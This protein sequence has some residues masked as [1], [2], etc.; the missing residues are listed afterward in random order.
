MH[1]TEYFCIVHLIYFHCIFAVCST[2][3][4]EG[5]EEDAVYEN[6]Q[7]QTFEAEDQ[8]LLNN[9]GKCNWSYCAQTKDIDDFITMHA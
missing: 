2:A 4:H 5:Y 8:Q 9:Q 1:D 3:A 6:F 7:V